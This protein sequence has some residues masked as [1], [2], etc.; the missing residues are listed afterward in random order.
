MDFHWTQVPSLFTKVW[1]SLI[2]WLFGDEVVNSSL[3][4]E[5]QLEDL[6]K[7]KATAWG[8]LVDS[9]ATTFWIFFW[10]LDDTRLLLE[11]SFKALDNVLILFR[12]EHLNSLNKKPVQV[13]EV[14]PW[15][16]FVPLRCFEV[17]YPRKNAMTMQC[18]QSF[19]QRAHCAFA[20]FS[21][22]L[23]EGKCQILRWPSKEWLQTTRL[24]F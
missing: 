4:V 11:E 10:W 22:V 9:M 20:M 24:I 15:A 19:F 3:T 23:S 18:W 8:Q 14:N 12:F 21:N 6:N 17:L 1:T 7:S 2:D 5:R 16:H 13:G